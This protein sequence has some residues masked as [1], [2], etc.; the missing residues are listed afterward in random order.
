[1]SPATLV[2]QL[3]SWRQFLALLTQKREGHPCLRVAQVPGEGVG[4]ALSFA[5][6]AWPSRNW[7]TELL[8]GLCHWQAATCQAFL[9]VENVSN[10]L[11][12]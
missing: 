6:C 2:L 4:M 3:V 7:G 5:L 12:K 8:P 9:L 1:M 10:F 11:L